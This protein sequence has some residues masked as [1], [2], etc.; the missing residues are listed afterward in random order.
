[1]A[2]APSEPHAKFEPQLDLPRVH[3]YLAALPAG[4]DS[5]PEAQTK[6]SV[7]QA[8]HALYPVAPTLPALPP[9]ARSELREPRAAGVWMSTVHANVLEL[10]CADVHG[11]S[12]AR[13]VDAAF[14]MNRRLLKGP[15]Y[16]AL[17]YVMSTALMLRTAAGSWRRFHVGSELTM[18][19][20]GSAGEITLTFPTHL[21][22]PLI[23]MEKAQAY[24][25]AIE[26]TGAH[27]VE[28][29]LDEVTPTSAHFTLSWR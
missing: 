25:A 27:E 20:A 6:A 10:A 1:M 17:F 28:A 26:A 8:L 9:A 11:L 19:A 3:A 15:M 21:H 13:F 22:P 23:L 2:V 12:D 14:E 16:R 4:M 24:R 7:Y 29:L 5:Y 18:R